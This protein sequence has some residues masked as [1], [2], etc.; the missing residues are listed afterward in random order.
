M[1]G[2]KWIM[3]NPNAGH[4]L[5]PAFDNIIET[6]MSWLLLLK[7]PELGGV[8]DMIWLRGQTFSGGRILLSTDRDPTDVIA[9]VAHSHPFEPVRKDFREDAFFPPM[10]QYIFWDTKPVEQLGTGLYD[11]EVDNV[12]PAYAAFFIE[13]QWNLVPGLTMRLT[14]EV[15]TAPDN[16]PFPECYGDS[17]FG[18]LV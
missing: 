2:P 18:T 8:P 6:V 14:T 7:E 10:P 3:M 1:G 9:W 16:Y 12:P 13:T 4:D 17:C 11:C 15:H 5:V